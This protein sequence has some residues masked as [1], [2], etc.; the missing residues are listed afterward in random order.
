MVLPP[1]HLCLSRRAMG[2]LPT[3]VFV[4]A[5]RRANLL[6]P[7]GVCTGS[8]GSSDGNAQN[9]FLGSFQ[10]PLAFTA[11]QGMR[12]EQHVELSVGT[13]TTTLLLLLRL[14]Y[15]P[16]CRRRHDDRLLVDDHVIVAGRCGG[17]L[18]TGS[19]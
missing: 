14:L 7:S 16:S 19:C 15:Q 5:P 13:D 11:C 6:L 1:G 18:L 8:G 2:R 12:V 17:K 3:W 4:L 10:T 9:W